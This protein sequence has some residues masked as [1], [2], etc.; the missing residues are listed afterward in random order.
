MTEELEYKVLRYLND[1]IEDYNIQDNQLRGLLHSVPDDRYN[2]LIESLLERKHIDHKTQNEK[3]WT[4]TN[5]GQ[6]ELN[7][8]QTNIN[9]RTSEN[10][11]ASTKFNTYATLILAIGAVVISILQYCQSSKQTEIM[12]KQLRLDSLSN[13]KYELVHDTVY[14]RCDSL[15]TKK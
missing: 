1:R 7:Y 6:K 9:N 3:G 4:I 13:T 10:L 2:K 11:I 8:L 5:D 12:E 14:I 15:T